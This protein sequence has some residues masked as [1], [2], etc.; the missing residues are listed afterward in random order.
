MTDDEIIAKVKK[1]F[2]EWVLGDIQKATKGDAKMGAFILASCFIDYLA[3]YYV[4]DKNPEMRYTTFVKKFLKNY[5]PNDL[6]HSLRNKFVHHYSEGGKYKFT[7]KEKAGKHL[8]ID[9]NKC[10][11]NLENFINEINNA[12]ESY[13][14]ELDNNKRLRYLCVKCYNKNPLLELIPNESTSENMSL[15]DVYLTS[16]STRSVTTIRLIDIENKRKK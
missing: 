7:D 10:I 2:R 12:M 9:G 4:N 5:K 8:D 1:T 16:G 15:N 13:F 3:R 11:I 14:S 6:Y